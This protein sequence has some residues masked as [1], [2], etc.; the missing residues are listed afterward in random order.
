[1]SLCVCE[2]ARV[3]VV[4]DYTE[5]ICDKLHLCICVILTI[6]DH[7]S[8]SECTLEVLAEPPLYT[9]SDGHRQLVCNIHQPMIQMIGP[10]GVNE[11]PV[12]LWS[13]TETER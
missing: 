10:L 2:R 9:G 7:D 12:P 5:Y 8:N 1:M 6:Q 4:Y 13:D 3:S 11:T